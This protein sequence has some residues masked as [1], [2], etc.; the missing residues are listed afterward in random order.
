MLDAFPE[1]WRGPS[2]IKR[3]A[4]KHVAESSSQRLMLEKGDVDVARN[5][6]V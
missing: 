5:N 2:K 6:F 1:Y 3:V 4:L